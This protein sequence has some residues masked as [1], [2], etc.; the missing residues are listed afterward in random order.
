MRKFGII[1]NE[2]CSNFFCAYSDEEMTLK[3][4]QSHIDMFAGTNVSHLFLN[5]VEQKATFPSKIYESA[6]DVDENSLTG[7]ALA[8]VGKKWFRHIRLLMEK[9]LDIYQV[10]IDRCRQH[11]ISPWLSMRMNDLHTVHEPANGMNNSFWRNNP[12]FWRVPDSLDDKGWEPVRCFERAFD[13]GHK[14]VREHHITALREMMERY[15]ADG[16]ELDWMR[17]PSHFQTGHEKEGSRILT[18][19]MREVRQLTNEWSAKRG[20]PMG[21]AARVPSHPVNARELGMDGLTWVREGLV[22]ILVPTPFWF[23]ADFDIPVELWR[24]MLGS[25]IGK[26]KIAGGVEAT[27]RVRRVLG[28]NAYDNIAAAR[29]QMVSLADR[30]ADMAY[31]F[32]YM[33][34]APGGQ[35]RGPSPGWTREAYME[36]INT[37]K[38]VFNDLKLPRRHIV[39]F[40]DS[41]PEGVAVN[42]LLPKELNGT[43]PAAFRIYTGPAPESGNVSIRAGLADKPGF[44]KVKLKARLNSRYCEAIEDL[45]LCDACD[46]KPVGVSFPRAARAIQFAVPLGMMDHGYNVVELIQPYGVNGQELVWVEIRIDP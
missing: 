30:G 46:P 33:Y 42:N 41:V 35:F 45:P 6:L 18:A 12:R 25:D 10:W 16:L 24:E 13:Y 29:G 3:T 19:F 23:S 21:L 37:G 31:L 39:T 5:C 40:D 26:A 22:D 14:E 32:N 36:L 4:C 44:E 9:G 8:D 43:T 38:D 20:H 1:L 15:D 34:N 17:F 11:G 2:D 7:F 28:D 27:L